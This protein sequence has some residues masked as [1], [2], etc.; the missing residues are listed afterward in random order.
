[1]PLRILFGDAL[2]EQENDMLSAQLMLEILQGFATEA[3]VAKKSIYVCG[4]EHQGHGGCF[5]SGGSSQ[6]G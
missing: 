5:A 4:G 2:R 6:G 3:D 1:M